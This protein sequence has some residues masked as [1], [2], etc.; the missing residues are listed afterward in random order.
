MSAIYLCMSSPFN[1]LKFFSNSNDVFGAVEGNFTFACGTLIGIVGAVFLPGD[2]L[3][4]CSTGLATCGS[5]WGCG[6]GCGAGFGC[7]TLG[8]GGAC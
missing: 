1:S 2:G 5:G 3:R 8:C 6:F 7:S 4:G